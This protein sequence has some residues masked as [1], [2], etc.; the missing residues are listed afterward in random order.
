MLKKLILLFISITAVA[1]SAYPYSNEEVTGLIEIVNNELSRLKNENAAEYAPEEIK[2]VNDRIT[3]S[4]TLLNNGKTDEAYFEA[5]IARSYFVLINAKKEY[6][7]AKKEYDESEK[8]L[9]AS[10]GLK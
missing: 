2:I 7:N 5:S 3:Q 10:G 4:G 1:S 6:F 8:N 9:K